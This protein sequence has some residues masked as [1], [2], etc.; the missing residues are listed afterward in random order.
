M[1]WSGDALL[2]S[3]NSMSVQKQKYFSQMAQHVY[4]DYINKDIILIP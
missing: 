3:S 2:T 1:V 4:V